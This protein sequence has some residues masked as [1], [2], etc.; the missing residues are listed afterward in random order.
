M[1]LLVFDLKGARVMPRYFYRRLNKLMEKQP[2]QRIQFSVYKAESK[3]AMEELYD[4]GKRYNF[5]VRIFR[6][7]KEV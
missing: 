7:E 2:I 3:E 6:I 4:L 5:E 1:Y